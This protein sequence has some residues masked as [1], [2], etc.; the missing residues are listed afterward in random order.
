MADRMQDG[1]V[2]HTEDGDNWAIEV[3]QKGTMTMK[4]LEKPEFRFE[5]ALNWIKRHH[6]E[7]TGWDK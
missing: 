3:W 5:H 1:Y 2:V 6:R 7:K 4:L